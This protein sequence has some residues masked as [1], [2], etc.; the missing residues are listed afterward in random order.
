VFSLTDQ[1]RDS[2]HNSYDRLAL[3]AIDEL[4]RTAGPAGLD[5]L[6]AEY[7]GGISDEFVQVKSENSEETDVQAL[8]VALS[9]AGYVASVDD[10]PSGEQLC[11][12]HCPVA[13]VAKRYPQLCEIETGMISGLLN[14]HVQRLATIAHGDGVCTTHIP[15][16]RPVKTG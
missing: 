12:H 7:F 15:K 14:S 16:A 9:D 10:L 1:G 4:L 3:A 13:D 6:A 5:R 8:A 11:Q 2:V